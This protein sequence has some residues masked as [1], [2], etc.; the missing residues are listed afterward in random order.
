MANSNSKIF[1]MFFSSAIFG[2]VVEDSQFM[3][4]REEWRIEKWKFSILI[5]FGRATGDLWK[6]FGWTERFN[7]THTHEER[8]DQR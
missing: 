2:H 6:Y 7:K 4:E 8:D 5:A 3:N 1:L